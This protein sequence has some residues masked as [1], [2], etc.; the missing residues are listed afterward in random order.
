MRRLR[1]FTFIELMV[2]IAIVVILIT[3]AIPKYLQN[4][5]RSR[6]AVLKSNLYSIR[7][8]INRYMYE[9]G[10]APKTIEDLKKEGYLKEIPVDPITGTN[11]SWRTV[12]EEQNAVMDVD[13]PG[14]GNVH[15]GSS[16]LALDGTHYYDW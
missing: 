10:K 16:K 6:E 14:F 8:C 11:T 1:G 9:Q 2:V 7:L 13:M 5:Q 4:I 3:M 15:S 12:P